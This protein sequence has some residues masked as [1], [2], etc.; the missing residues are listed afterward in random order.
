MRAVPLVLLVFLISNPC[1]ALRLLFSKKSTTNKVTPALGTAFPTA[2][3][4]CCGCFR[5]KYAWPKN[6]GLAPTTAPSK[7]CGTCYVADR[8]GIEGF[9]G[10]VADVSSP[11]YRAPGERA[12]PLVTLLQNSQPYSEEVCAEAAQREGLELGGV[13]YDFTG[14]YRTKGCYTYASGK[15]AGH[16][17][18]GLGGTEEDRSAEPSLPKTRVMGHDGGVFPQAEEPEGR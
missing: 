12:T 17:Y 13:G 2:V 11:G 5:S 16:A 18:Y 4:A 15:Y 7:T 9:G 10:G 14:G 1:E 8:Y 6:A 3:A